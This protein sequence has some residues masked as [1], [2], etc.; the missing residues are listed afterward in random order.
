VEVW[1]RRLAGELF[2]DPIVAEVFSKRLSA[3]SE[4]LLL[5]GEEDA[6]RLAAAA[7]EGLLGG[8]AADQPFVRALVRRDLEL[9]LQAVRQAPAEPGGESWQLGQ[10]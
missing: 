5:A 10:T 1:V 4:W 2:A 8:N 6:S 9:A 3:M 7:A